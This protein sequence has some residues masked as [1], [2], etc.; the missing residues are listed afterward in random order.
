MVELPLCANL[1]FGMAAFTGTR[2]I[3]DMSLF[4]VIHHGAVDPECQAHLIPV[5]G[6][7]GKNIG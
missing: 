1:F 3:R 7:S 5:L 6:I 2:M 4:P